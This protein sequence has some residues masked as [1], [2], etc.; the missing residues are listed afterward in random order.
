MANQVDM[1]NQ[2][3]MFKK[4]KIAKFNVVIS[5]VSVLGFLSF[6]ILMNN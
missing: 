3:E 2:D 5:G 4:E 6:T 1:I